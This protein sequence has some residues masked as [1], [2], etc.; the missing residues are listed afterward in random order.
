ML[1]NVSNWEE[2]GRAHGEFFGDIRPASTLVEISRLVQLD[3]LV[4]IEADCVIA[5]EN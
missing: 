5:D 1:T 4:E 3:W 2:V